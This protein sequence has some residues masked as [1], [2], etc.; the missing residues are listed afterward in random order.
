MVQPVS[1]RSRSNSMSWN[2]VA[3]SRPELGSSRKRIAGLA[4]NST[5]TL[6]RLRWPPESR[7]IGLLARARR[8]PSWSIVCRSSFCDL[9]RRRAGGQP[10]PRAEAQRLGDGEFGMDDV[11]L[12]HEAERLRGRARRKCPAP[13]T[14]TAPRSGARRP[15]S[16]VSSEDLPAPLGPMM[17]TKR[18]AGM[19][20]VMSS[21]MVSGPERMKTCSARMVPP[22]ALATR[23]S[24]WPSN[25]KQ[26]GPICRRSPTVSSWVSKRWPLTKEPP[27]L[28]RS[29]DEAAAARRAARG[30]RACARRRDR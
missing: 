19:V 17:P 25:W 5:P 21:R 7:L 24:A 30:W 15:L 28:L 3:G 18:D 20:S 23:L 26:N 10:Q 8:R 4:S 16:V 29:R 13:S 2:S 9:E 22:A 1:A 14:R 12:R 11:V 6:T 27:V